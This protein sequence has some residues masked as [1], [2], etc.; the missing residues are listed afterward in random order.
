MVVVWWSPFAFIFALA[1]ATYILPF[2]M[3]V[4]VLAIS[5]AFAMLV[6]DGVGVSPVLF[7]WPVVLRVEVVARGSFR[8]VTS[9]SVVVVVVSAVVVVVVLPTGVVVA[10]VLLQF[11]EASGFVVSL[12]SLA[13]ELE[14]LVSTHFILEFLD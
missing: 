14:D 7:F 2:A 1:F 13:Y 5:F 8:P 4:M 11:S 6:V 9:T 10:V 3:L 12:E